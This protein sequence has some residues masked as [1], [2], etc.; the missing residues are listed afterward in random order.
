METSLF[1]PPGGRVERHFSPQFM[2][3]VRGPL[4]GEAAHAELERVWPLLEAAILAYAP[5]H[6]IEHVRVKLDSGHCQIWTT[7]NAAFVSEIR[8]WPTG[9]REAIGWLAGGDLDELLM[10]Q[11]AFEAWARSKD[12]KRIGI[13]LGREGWERKLDGYRKTGIQLVKDLNR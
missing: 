5:T 9:L 1:R 4:D 11:P 13:Q 2:P 3:T 10:M 12:C 6:R 7:P 8:V